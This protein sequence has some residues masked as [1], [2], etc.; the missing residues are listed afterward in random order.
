MPIKYPHDGRMRGIYLLPN[1]FTTGGLLAGFYAIVAAM[2]G[3]FDVACI[4]VFIAMLTDAIDGRVARLTHTQSAF[5][6]EYDSLADMVSFGIAPSIIVFTW[7]L[8]DFG[9]LGWLATFFYVAAGALRLAR[10]NTQI[11]SADKRYFQGLAIPAAAGLMASMVWAGKQYNMSGNLVS[12]WMF[13][14]MI[15]TAGLMVSNIRY[16]SFKSIDLKGRV[17]FVAILCVVLIFA[18]ISI[19]PPT[20][21]CLITFIYCLSGPILTLWNLRKKRSLRKKLEKRETNKI[22]SLAK[23]RDRKR[24]SGT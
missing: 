13:F 14:W 4:A 6:A 19:D 11:Q 12:I 9:K 8:A 15:V 2:K 17:S 3:N 1:L 24:R 7:A 10:F 16:Y 23:I 20:V 18:A 22:V 5:G 21:L